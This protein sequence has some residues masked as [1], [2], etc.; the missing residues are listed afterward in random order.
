MPV[1]LLHPVVGFKDLWI[2]E[3]VIFSLANEGAAIVTD[4]IMDVVVVV[5]VDGHLNRS[6]RK[7]VFS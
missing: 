6:A 1:L 3:S 5:A 2:V 4:L 7:G